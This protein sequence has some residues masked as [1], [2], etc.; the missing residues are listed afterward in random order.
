INLIIDDKTVAP[1]AFFLTAFHNF[2]LVMVQLIKFYRASCSSN[3]FVTV[4]KMERIQRI[5]N[6]HQ[7]VLSSQ[8]FR[9]VDVKVCHIKGGADDFLESFRLH[10]TAE[11][12]F[13]LVAAAR[14]EERRV[15]KEC[16]ARWVG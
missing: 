2:K 12:I 8:R 13:Y 7:F 14:S 15:G 4:R 16:R 6:R 10:Y 1:D 5:S 9:Q 11:R 3:R